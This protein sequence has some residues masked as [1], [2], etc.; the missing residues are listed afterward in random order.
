M[1]AQYERLRACALGQHPRG[2]C[3]EGLRVVARGG[4]G[5]WV[6]EPVVQ[7]AAPSIAA[8]TPRP[9]A[10][11]EVMGTLTEMLLHH[12]TEATP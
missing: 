5:V 1:S 11:P 6:R 12:L 10:N 3:A 7:A 9:S 4:V 2:G 8:A